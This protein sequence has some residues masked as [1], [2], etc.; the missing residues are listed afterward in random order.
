[1]AAPDIEIVKKI[2]KA[3]KEK[4]LKLSVAE[5][6][7]GGLISHLITNLPGASQFFD[8]SVV[9][10][11]IESKIKLLGLARSVIKRSGAIS[12][13]TARAIAVAIRK[14]RKTDFSLSITG[15]LGPE[16]IE[17]KQVGLVYM[18]VDWDRETISREMIFDGD[19][20]K[21]KHKAA[22]SSLELLREAID[23]WT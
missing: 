22:I 23:A 17:G 12:E 9:C 16:A 6:C 8:S 18:A 20:E 1:M 13:E 10:Y 19:R 7:T 4:G 2:H 15:N 11:S 3:F 5:S 21:I 14:K